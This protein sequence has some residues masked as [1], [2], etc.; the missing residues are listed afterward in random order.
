MAG[1]FPWTADLCNPIN[2][3]VATGTSTPAAIAAGTPANVKGAWT[4]LGT[5]T[6][7]A[8]AALFQVAT[9][10]N[11]NISA[12]VDFGI[13]P[14][15]SQVVIVNN[16]QTRDGANGV[17][18]SLNIVSLFLPMNI[19]AGTTLWARAQTIIAGQTVRAQVILFD[20]GYTAFDGYSGVDS[21]GF[22]A[23]STNGVTVTAATPANNKG[24]Y[25]Q[26]AVATRDYAGIALGPMF[27]SAATTTN[28]ADVAVGAAGSEVVII[29]NLPL[30]QVNQAVN[31]PGGVPFFPIEISAG[32]RISM[33][34]QSATASS[35]GMFALYA[36]YR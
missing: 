31:Y 21:L 19:K 8:V 2:L 18:A 34:M 27:A 3:G 20:G 26:I 28:L 4:S 11:S 25:A 17:A 7:D 12:A 22:V 1:G 35:T 23:A 14:S 6:A 24:A 9:L 16:I 36:A 33:R 13:G 30:C 29:P 32:T 10:M 15:G 5:A